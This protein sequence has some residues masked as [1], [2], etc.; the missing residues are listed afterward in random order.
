MT[1]TIILASAS[2]I[3]RNLLESAGLQPVVE[4]ARID[5]AAIKAAL[6]AENANPHDIAD[7]LAEMKALRVSARHPGAIVIGADQVLDLGGTMLDKPRDMAEARAQL[8]AMR[9][10]SH[11][12]ISAAVIV[13]GGVAIWRHAGIVRLTMR[14]FSE[15]YLDSYLARGGEDLLHSVGA[16]KLEAEG[17]RLFASIEGDYFTVLGLPL[18]EVLTHLTET[19]V[20]P[21]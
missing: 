4:A 9:G 6:L 20:L 15:D 14:E 13:R 7:A 17:V 3:R 2:T 12:L 1:P 8:L 21:T 11:R 5:E 19:R 18:L 10:R 16:Y